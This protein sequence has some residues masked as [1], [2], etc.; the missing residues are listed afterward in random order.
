MYKAIACTEIGVRKPSNQDSCCLMEAETSYG[1]AMLMAVCD[2][3]GGLEHGEVASAVAV[4]CLIDWFEQQFPVFIRYNS[5]AG[6][7]NLGGLR[8][9]FAQLFGEM[10]AKVAKIA[11]EREQRMATT[12]TCVLVMQGSAAIGHVGDSR[13]FLVRDGEALQLTRD[14]SLVA[15][16]VQ[17]GNLTEE[18][19]ARH[20]QRNILLQA[21]G[22]QSEIEPF[23]DVV[24]VKQGDCFLTCC[25]GFYHE[26]PNRVLSE[27]FANA[28]AL[29]ESE[30]RNRCLGLIRC[31]IDA[32]E[33]DNITVVCGVLPGG[34]GRM[35]DADKR[36]AEDDET[37]LLDDPDD[38]GTALLG[39]ESD[40]GTDDSLPSSQSEHVEPGHP[41]L[42]DDI[43]TGALSEGCDETVDLT[44]SLDETVRDEDR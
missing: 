38:D 5:E 10:N 34:A 8:G 42:D 18:Q 4:S 30:L 32:G 26:I 16:E 40:A 11:Q 28:S 36:G 27:T 15:R 2:G 7:V 9:V 1:P 21:L 37:A 41:L 23:V 13:A 44:E 3:V 6:I 20:P 14:Q 19:A 12:C 24:H 29:T 25:D 33:T 22:A 35:A 43:P 39:V 17:R 31:A